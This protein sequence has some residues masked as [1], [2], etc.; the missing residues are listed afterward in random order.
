MKISLNWLNEYLTVKI[1]AKEAEEILTDVGLEVEDVEAYE[2]IPGGLKG[3][4]IGEVLQKEKH[5]D[6][7]RLSVTKVNIGSE[8]P[9]QIVCGAP[10]VDQGQKVIVATVGTT[11]YPGGEKLQIKKSKIR[12]V[13]SKG[14]ICAED[15]VG[16]GTSHEGI[17]VLP[18]EYEV[19]AEASKYFD[20]ESDTII[21]INI[22]PNRSDATSHL[23]VARDIV[24]FQ[25]L[26]NP[27]AKINWPSVE[28]NNDAKGTDIEIV[29][30][31]EADCPR[32]SGVVIDNLT[33]G[34]SPQWLK[35]KL[36]SIGLR[37]INLAVDITNY[38][39]LEL[40]HPLHA[41]DAGKIDGGKVVV[42][43]LKDGTG[44]KTLDEVDRK[45]SS[46]DLMICSAT[47]PMCIAGVFGGAESGVTEGTTKIFLE[48]AYFHPVSIR[49]TAKFH[50]LHTD[51]S[52]RFER[53]ADPNMTLKA[54]K[55][56]TQLLVEMGNGKVVSEWMD[57]Y[58]KPI[59]NHTIEFSLDKLNLL[60]G[61]QIQEEIV[62]RIL[63]ALEIS[64]DSKQGQVWVLSVP[65]FKV[66]V[67]RD[68]DVVE[69]VLR[70]YGYNEVP[71]KSTLEAKFQIKE[72]DPYAQA[73]QKITSLLTSNGYNEIITNSLLNSRYEEQ[74]LGKEV[75]HTVNLMNPIS[76]E[77]DILR[78]QMIFS[79]LEVV[80][81][82]LN[83]KAPG[84]KIFEIG[85]TYRFDESSKENSFRDKHKESTRL[86]VW[87]AEELSDENWFSK[88]PVADYYQ[89]KGIAESI[90]EALSIPVQPSTQIQHQLLQTATG[91]YGFKDKENPL[92]VYGEVSKKV[93]KVMDIKQP[94]FYAEFNWDAVIELMPKTHKVYTPV[95]KYPSVR[96]DLALVLDKQIDYESLKKTAFKKLK[97]LLAEVNIFD[98]YEGKG[99]PDGKKSY[100]LS[101][102]FKDPE[103][104]LK[105]EE[106]D[107]CME[108]LI[109]EFKSAYKAEIRS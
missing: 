34:E 91:I 76:S 23:G 51:A 88:T 78:N 60:S 84:I 79:G 92:A 24:A 105:D 30:E 53:G 26:S 38:V 63:N 11:L 74:V 81:Y 44:F 56:A 31:N 68:V 55:R 42:K 98:V 59:S 97:S 86:G 69:E 37:P 73:H 49:K 101:F 27:N 12:G 104:T 29:V 96:R 46:K 8:E 43:N 71:I 89:I 39:Q 75:D 94:V 57:H 2:S 103:R 64:I 35:N 33:I 61:M 109:E 65:P 6:A 47:K 77:L 13:E 52:F 108:K 67:T 87:I 40:G 20:V 62:E 17:M 66:D 83:H 41:F 36:V 4:I 14:M 3:L 7:D 93:L 21:D 72:K 100:A 85:K 90:F 5:P 95:S 58:P 54:L 25:K 107:D 106:V 32:Y 102:I 22:T 70:V 10:N 50:G 15:E 99:I 18:N 45:L 19:G 1:S 28:I 48:A 9:L 16:L 82:N 80:S